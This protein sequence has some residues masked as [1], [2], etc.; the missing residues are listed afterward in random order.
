[1][2]PLASTSLAPSSENAILLAL[3]EHRIRK[4]LAFTYLT[5]NDRN[6][7]KLGVSAI[8]KSVLHSRRKFETLALQSSIAPG[9][10]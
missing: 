7:E 2:S 8:D 9:T 3:T 10:T 4:I 6:T 1:M 5:D